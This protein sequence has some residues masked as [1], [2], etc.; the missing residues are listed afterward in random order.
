MIEDKFCH[1][2]MVAIVIMGAITFVIR[3]GGFWLI[4]YV[5]VSDRMRRMLEA[6]PGSI[7]AAVV[8]P[9]VAK[10]GAAGVFALAAALTVMLAFRSTLLGVMVGIAAAA[11]VRRAGL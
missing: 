3:A 9:I 10:N 5:Q 6:L 8:L 7:V 1:A 11:L 2:G 4:G